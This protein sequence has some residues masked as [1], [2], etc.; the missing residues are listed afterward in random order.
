MFAEGL[1]WL[2]VESDTWKDVLGDDAPREAR[3][4]YGETPAGTPMSM[5]R[6]QF[7]GGEADPL[8]GIGLVRYVADELIFGAHADSENE[9]EVDLLSVS[10]RGLREWLT[11]WTKDTTSPLAPVNLV[12][13]SAEAVSAKPSDEA[14]LSVSIELDGV[15]MQARVDRSV[16]TTGRFR[17]VYETTARLH[18]KAEQ[19]KTLAAWRAE[20][21]QPLRDL[22]LFGTREQTVILSLRGRNENGR[23][24]IR[25]YQAPDV[26]V[27]APDHSEYYQRD[28]LPAGI[29][30]QDGFEDL[31]RTWRELYQR[32]G[33]VAPALFEVWNTV[34]M[35]PLTR[36]LRLTSCAEGYHR[37]LH[38]RPPFTPSEHDAMVEAMIAALPEES[39]LVPD[40][41]DHYRKELAHANRESQAKRFRRLVTAAARADVRLKREA[42]AIAESLSKWRNDQTHLAGELTMPPRDE[43]LLLNAVL[44]YVLEAN[45]L[46]DLGIEEGTLYC[47][48]HGHVWDDPIP[49][50]LASALSNTGKKKK[51]KS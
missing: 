29:W 41:R 39:G 37:K 47:L 51:P 44:T 32:L 31:I 24:E 2:D 27:S 10:F 22:V 14:R 12:E 38:D 26:V 30:D 6:V 17:T 48:A 33:P 43:L 13:S 16:A 15:N 28:L 21:V 23:T 5:Q 11:G 18:F 42:Q 20:W 50:W 46:L 36:L 25:V 4:L 19:P 49:A 7:F 45:V 34:D 1:V 35:P 3:T 40:P 8:T 9:V